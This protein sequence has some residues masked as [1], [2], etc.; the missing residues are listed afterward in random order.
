[1]QFANSSKR[2]LKC[3]NS[4]QHTISLRRFYFQDRYSLSTYWFGTKFRNS[5]L[6]TESWRQKDR[7]S[8]DLP[9]CRCFRPKLLIFWR[10]C[11]YQLLYTNMPA[12]PSRSLAGVSLAL[13]L[14]P[15][16]GQHLP[17]RLPMARL[18]SCNKSEV[19]RRTRCT[20]KGERNVV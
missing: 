7:T 14:V 1:V 6:T 17:S 19:P 16:L 18:R 10:K 20:K 8:T 2:E 11:G 3:I 5:R 12:S 13:S 9:S 15:L 4:K